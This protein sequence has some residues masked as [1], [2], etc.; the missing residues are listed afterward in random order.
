MIAGNQDSVA[1]EA[2]VPVG[3]S[4]KRDHVPP[5]DADPLVHQLGVLAR[6]G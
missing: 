3:V 4:R 2:E 6:S 1:D 5:V